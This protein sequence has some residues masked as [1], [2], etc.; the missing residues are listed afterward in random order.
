M[1]VNCQ[2]VLLPF[3]AQLP[4]GQLW[5]ENACDK[6]VYTKM[7]TAKV[8][9]TS[10]RWHHL[11]CF[12]GVS[13][14]QMCW[15]LHVTPGMGVDTL[16]VAACDTPLCD[17]ALV[18]YYRCV[19]PVLPQGPSLQVS[20]GDPPEARAICGEGISHQGRKPLSLI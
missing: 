19:H 9:R 3:M 17:P 20:V 12:Y 7:L 1:G 18:T 2:S 10:P 11:S 15:G 13:F 6:D 5:S 4:D 16:P 8:P 14:L